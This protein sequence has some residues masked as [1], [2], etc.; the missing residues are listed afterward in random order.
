MRPVLTVL[1]SFVLAAWM[2]LPVYASEDDIEYRQNVYKALGGH[3]SASAAIIQNE[4]SQPD[5]LLVH[6]RNIA[7]IADL[8]PDLFP[9][10]S[11]DGDTDALAG[12]W[13]Q[14]DAFG[15]RLSAFQEAAA[16]F[17]EAAG[18]GNRGATAQ[19]F[20]SMAQT[21]RGCHDDFRD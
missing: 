4:V 12:I 9:E 20:M 8:L 13:E 7:Q 17:Y 11:G 3:T 19:A 5:H 10:G 15:E 21:C 1:V 2:V 16:G 6:A 18:A 14:P